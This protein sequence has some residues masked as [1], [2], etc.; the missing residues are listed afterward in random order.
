MLIAAMVVTPF[1]NNAATVL[2]MAPIAASF[3]AQLG[4][5]PDAFLMAVAIGAGCDFLTPIG[6]Q[7]NTLV[8][9]PGGYRFGDYARLGAPL[10]LLVIAARRAADHD[11]VAA[12]L[13]FG[14]FTRAGR[15]GFAASVSSTVTATGSSACRL[16][17][18]CIKPSSALEHTPMHRR[19]R[20]AFRRDVGVAHVRIDVD[21]LAGLE[22]DR[23]VEL[24]V[25]LHAAFDDVDVLLAGV[26]HELAELGDAARADAREHRDHALAAQLGAQ[27]VV[28]VV[29]GV[30]ADR[31][32]DAPDTA[33][34]GHRRV[35]HGIALGEQLGHADVEPMAELLQLVV[36]QREAVV[37]D[38]GERRDRDAGPLAHLLERPVVACPELTQQR[39]ERRLFRFHAA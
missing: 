16:I 24:R 20:A 11:R 21:R 13:S 26:V 18:D 8:M 32:V 19:F 17:S 14:R 10:S 37:L 22:R 25:D 38:L 9:G 5:R 4:Y 7:C 12:V 36:R 2:V 1:L 28:V 31:A 23:V 29:L 35:G 15:S 30:D 39:P 6:H 27:V 3:A 34:R 33:P